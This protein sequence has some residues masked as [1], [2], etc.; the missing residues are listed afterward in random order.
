[1]SFKNELS[2]TQAGSQPSGNPLLGVR[3]DV[4]WHLTGSLVVQHAGPGRSSRQK[5]R[6]KLGT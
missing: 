1:M 3:Y 2:K 5:A 6:H 4:P